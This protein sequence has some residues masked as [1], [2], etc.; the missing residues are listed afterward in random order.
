MAL[1]SNGTK[2]TPY[3]ISVKEAANIIQMTPQFV[4]DAIRKKGGPPAKVFGRRI[5]LR[6]ADFLKWAEAQSNK[7]D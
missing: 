6:H 1:Q 5:R 4:Y 7:Q 2:S 3:F